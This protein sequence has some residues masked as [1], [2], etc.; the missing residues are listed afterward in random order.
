MIGFYTL[1]DMVFC[2]LLLL[3]FQGIKYAADYKFQDN[4]V[5]FIC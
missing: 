5:D 4:Y 2:A 1:R 3:L